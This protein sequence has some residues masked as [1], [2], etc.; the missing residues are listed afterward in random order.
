MGIKG[1]DPEGVCPRLAACS[2]LTPGRAPI[3]LRGLRVLVVAVAALTLAPA[4]FGSDK[5]D[6]EATDVSLQVNARGEALVSYTRPGG[7]IRRVLVWGAVNALPPDPIRPQVRFRFDYSGGW[8]K[9]GRQIWRSFPNRCRPYDGP[10]LVFLVAACKAPD[11]SYWALQQWQRNLPMRGF[12]PFRP[13]HA[14]YELHVSHWT[15]EL[16]VLEVSPNWTYDGQFQGLFGRMTYGGA[17]VHGFRTPSDRRIEPYAR[18][19]YIDTFNSAYG[20]GWKHDAAKVTHLRNGAFCYS[21]VPQTPP[22]GYPSDAPRGPGNGERHRVIAM[23]PGVTP[24]VHWEGA[25]L[26]PFDP[27]R[28][29]AFNELFDRIVGPD[30]R[31]CARER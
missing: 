5:V 3:S 10:A 4:A 19:V 31:V 8:K 12:D 2:G 1:T 20:A 7:R 6:A 18:Y 17:A 27:E 25:G 29:A 30:D 23:G 16:P 28:D 26:G 15:G 24:V 9:Y 14:A 21:F 11:G 22:P 13:G